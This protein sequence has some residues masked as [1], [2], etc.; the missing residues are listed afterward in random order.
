MIILDR[1][2][3]DSAVLE[4]DGQTVSVS[5]LLLKE[6][7]KEGTVLI[8]KDNMYLPDKALTDLRKKQISAL[9]EDLFD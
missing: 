9:Q 4:I 3:G 1:Y 8:K 6:K 2:E 7:C 5:A